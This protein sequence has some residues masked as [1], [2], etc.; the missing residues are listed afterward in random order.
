GVG[1]VCRRGRQ[2]LAGLARPGAGSGPGRFRRGVD[3]G[4]QADRLGGVE[5]AAPGAPVEPAVVPPV[6]AWPTWAADRC[7]NRDRMRAATPATMPL[8]VLVE[9]IR[10]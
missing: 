4:G 9:L 5:G 10:A 7:G 8:D 3:G 2:A 1:P 6:S